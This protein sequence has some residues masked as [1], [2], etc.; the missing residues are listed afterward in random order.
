MKIIEG[1]HP[2]IREEEQTDLISVIVTAYNI[3]GYIER[4]VKSVCAQTY[5]NLEDRKST[6]LN[7]SHR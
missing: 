5:R 6:R 4:G 7:S 1:Y 2:Q 3:G